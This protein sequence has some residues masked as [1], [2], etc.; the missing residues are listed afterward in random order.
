MFQEYH[1]ITRAFLAQFIE[2]NCFPLGEECEQHPIVTNILFPSFPVAGSWVYYYNIGSTWPTFF[3]NAAASW[4]M[5]IC[6]IMWLGFRPRSVDF[7]TFKCL[8]FYSVLFSFSNL[9]SKNKS[10][11]MKSKWKNDDFLS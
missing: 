6:T 9:L 8:F 2:K 7:I 10:R 5:C 4:S 11:M 1:C 3:T